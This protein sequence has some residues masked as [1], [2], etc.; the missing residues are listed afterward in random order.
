MEGRW[1]A[2]GMLSMGTVL[3]VKAPALKVGRG[4]PGAVKCWVAPGKQNTGEHH[5]KKPTVLFLKVSGQSTSPNTSLFFSSLFLTF[6]VWLVY[7]YR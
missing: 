6:S 7:S 2:K 4:G 1:Q 3:A 5:Q